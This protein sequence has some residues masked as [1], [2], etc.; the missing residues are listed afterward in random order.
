MGRFKRKIALG[1]IVTLMLTLFPMNSVIGE[2][3]REENKIHIESTYPLNNQ[4]NVEVNPLI[5]FDFK[6]K[7][8]LTSD[9]KDKIKISSDGDE[10]AVN[11]DK[12]AFVS[13]EGN[14][15][16]IDVNSLNRGGKFNL[17]EDT[18]YKV[19]LEEGAL[20][21]KD[22]KNN[23]YV[24]VFNEEENLYFITGK[25][26]MS[27]NKGLKVEKY[28]SNLE[29]TDRINYINQTQLDSDG[30]IY[31]HFNKNIQWNKYT[32]GVRTDKQALKY[33]ELYKKPK[34]YEENKS[35]LYD[36]RKSSV[37][38]IN[39]QVEIES[40]EIIKDDSGNN[41]NILKIKPKNN[42]INL[43][44]YI[45]KMNKKEILISYEDDVLN[46]NIAQSL[47]TKA[48]NNK[49]IPKWDRESSAEE[50]IEDQNA[51]N[52]EGYVIRGTPRYDENTPITILV[53]KEIILKPYEGYRSPLSDVEF[54]EYY[55]GSKKSENLKDIKNYK[56]EYY[57]EKGVKKT[58]IL[59]YPKNPAE[60]GKE[61]KLDIKQGTFV[62]R[63]NML[64]EA[65]NLR[66]VVEGDTREDKG[67]NNV[68][69]TVDGEVKTNEIFDDYLYFQD[70]S[71]A[72]RMHDIGFE[73][74]GYNFTEDIEKIEFIKVEDYIIDE[75][76]EGQRQF[77]RRELEKEAEESKPGNDYPGKPEENKLEYPKNIE[78]STEG[79]EFESVNKITGQFN[80]EVLKEL[81]KA[82]SLGEYEVVITFKQSINRLRKGKS[83]RSNGNKSSKIS[84]KLSDCRKG[85]KLLNH[86]PREGAVIDHT[87]LGRITVNFEDIHGNV[88]S[89]LDE[90][91]G[92]ATRVEEFKVTELGK[93]EDLILRDKNGKKKVASKQKRGTKKIIFDIEL[94]ISKLKEDTVYEVTI[95]EDS[96]R[97]KFRYEPHCNKNLTW[98]F[99]TTSQ[100]K[101]EKIYQGSVPENYDAS[102]PL[103]IKGKNLSS[104][105][106]VRF[107]NVSTG[108]TY[109]IDRSPKYIK[110]DPKKNNERDKLMIYLPK[111]DKLPVGLYNILVYSGVGLEDEYSD[112]V[113]SV[114]EN[115]KYV[116]NEEYTEKDTI[117]NGNKVENSLKEIIK[118]SQTELELLSRYTGSTLDLDQIM[119]EEVLTRDIKYLGS[120]ISD[121]NTRSKWS[122]VR[123]KGI[124][125][126]SSR[127]ITIRLGRAE[128]QVSDNLKRRLRGENIKSEMI[129]VSGEG[130]SAE[131]LNLTIPYKQSNGENLTVLRYDEQSR[132]VNKIKVNNENIN[133]KDKFV[134]IDLINA[135]PSDNVT[136][137]IFVV[138]E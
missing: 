135:L 48:S 99:T 60:A 12:D 8:E 13:F 57:M 46:F 124:K 27:S 54:Y 49:E 129:I 6:Q 111:K 52:K 3:E 105:L 90:K 45:L 115:G 58:K 4:E 28:S 137:G 55:E 1:L 51:P 73:L 93:D 78:I 133:K 64:L 59:L 76:D 114:V 39:E 22:K 36:I 87:R 63:G 15:L 100:A 30:N 118:T 83:A 21:L 121:L 7:V 42:L 122:N 24:D 110:A 23:P 20:K 74:E 19:T 38:S 127:P 113:F 89:M 32:E 102:Y 85:P 18:A 125:S 69:I 14:T 91:S 53:D 130:Y 37:P 62:T 79:V 120:F 5:Q 47:W 29:G 86:L 34:E 112:G 70:D 109:L 67:I 56:I 25:D 71:D 136:K 31:L 116:P 61:Y 134:E 82:S 101:A 108:K 44:E 16:K 138:V 33:F 11:L 50:I 132:R 10:L 43:N 2:I 106:T 72:K 35:Y 95:P 117:V 66:F 84:N 65:I 131:K 97:C 88:K 68:K 41:S 92:I 103:I 9:Y 17:R 81:S 98:R 126:N 123:L 96:V 77:Y 119:G 128:P 94:D 75:E 26:K 104:G 80:E 107:K 40:V